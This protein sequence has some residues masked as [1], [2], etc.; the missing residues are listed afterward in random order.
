MKRGWIGEINNVPGDGNGTRRPWCDKEGTSGRGF[1]SR[2]AG[3][4]EEEQGEGERDVGSK[5]ENCVRDALK[6]SGKVGFALRGKVT[7]IMVPRAARDTGPG[8]GG[9]GW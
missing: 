5:L 8:G 9:G 7:V 1:G 6:D 4:D 2:R 3:D